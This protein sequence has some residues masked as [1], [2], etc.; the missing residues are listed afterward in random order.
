VVFYFLLLFIPSGL[1]SWFF[2]SMSVKRGRS[3]SGQR[4]LYSINPPLFLFLD[5]LSYFRRRSVFSVFCPPLVF[6]L[7]RLDRNLF[8]SYNPTP[9]CPFFP[10]KTPPPFA[11]KPREVFREGPPFCCLCPVLVFFPRF[12]LSFPSVDFGVPT[13][14]DYVVL[15]L[16]FFLTV[17]LSPN[18]FLF[19]QFAIRLLI[20][21]SAVSAVPEPLLR[22]PGEKLPLRVLVPTLPPPTP[23]LGVQGKVFTCSSTDQLSL[24]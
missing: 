23:I 11:R 19:C 21:S 16:F 12:L 18:P 2:T 4:G 10:S 6:L 8:K 15:F 13:F 5:F 1:S 17:L 3:S 9:V 20:L 22:T 14:H 24:Q 7:V